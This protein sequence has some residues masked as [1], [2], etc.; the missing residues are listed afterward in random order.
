MKFAIATQELNTLVARCLNVV[1]QKAAIPILANLL[2]EADSNSITVTATDLTVGICCHVK[3]KVFHEGA[4]AIPAKKLAQLMRELSVPHIE[5]STNANEVTEISAGSSLFKLNGMGKREFPTLPNMDGAIRFQIKEADLK[6]MLFYTSFAVSRE[7]SRYVLTGVC[8]HIANSRATFTGTDGKKLALASTALEIDHT[9]VGSYIIPLKAVEELLKSLGEGDSIA[10]VALLS[11]KISV[12]MQQCIIVSK[13]LSGDFP[14]VKR[15]IP[16]KMEKKI[17]LHKEELISLLRQVSLFTDENHLS[18]R[19][20]FSPG[21]LRL[22]ANTVEIGEG[23]VSMPADYHGETLEI[24][25]NPAFFIDI[26]RHCKNE[27]IT[28]GVSDSYNPGAILDGENSDKNLIDQSPLF[29]LMP[30][31]LNER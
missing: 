13:L 18:V 29:I 28:L 6:Q 31:R 9:F 17:P 30:M 12:E 20:T 1:G 25:F 23:R 21:E 15:V 14:D 10:H 5:V 22:S 11:D 3:A 8:M 16:E 24:A 2:I 26:L 19:F 27:V 7:D 4:T